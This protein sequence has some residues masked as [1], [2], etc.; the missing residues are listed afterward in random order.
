MTDSIDAELSIEISGHHAAMLDEMKEEAD[1]DLDEQIVDILERQC[2]EPVESV[3]H[4]AY[5]RMNHQQE[6]QQAQSVQQPAQ[7]PPSNSNND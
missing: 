4:N 6:Q 2:S 3:I 5:Q 1:R 7:S